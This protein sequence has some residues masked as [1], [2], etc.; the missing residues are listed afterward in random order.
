MTDTTEPVIIPRAAASLLVLQ[1]HVERGAPPRVL[2]GMR[3]ARHRFMPNRLV[4]PGGAV[5]PADHDAAVA[6][7]LAPEV[8]RRLEKSAPASLARALGV[9]AAREL[10]E[11]TG[12]SL[13]E[14]PSLHGL[15]YLCRAVTPPP[16]PMR[17]DARFLVVDAAHVAGEIA[18]SGEL[19]DLRWWEIEEALG[20]DLAGPQRM[21]LGQLKRWMAMSPAERLAPRPVPVLYHREWE[22]E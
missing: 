14:P 8:L 10:L 7:H 9:A 18:G 15:D 11:E 21:V 12:L 22:E 20:T 17:F 3:G 19:E 1:G 2:M 6:S 13:G 4:F 16:S 5:D